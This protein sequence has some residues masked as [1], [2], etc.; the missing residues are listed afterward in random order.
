M[1][2]ENDV[3]Q[4]FAVLGAAYP[5]YGPK[6]ETISLYIRLLADIPGDALEKAVLEH[7]GRNNWFPTIAE[8]RNAAFALL[9]AADP[10]P[11]EYQ[12]WAEV[13]AEIQ[14]V[15]HIGQPQFSHPLIARIVEQFGWRYLCLSEDPVPDRAQFL[16]AYGGQAARAREETRRLP[17]V[18]E[19]VAAL[20]ASRTQAAP[21]LQS[22]VMP[23]PQEVQR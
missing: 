9:E 10:T 7:L 6:K 2:T 12:A 4:C 11:D 20:G 3:L 22:V 13:Q 5:N 8:L 15:G 19:Y 23:G 14:R 17:E 21:A 16:K 18:R 1:A